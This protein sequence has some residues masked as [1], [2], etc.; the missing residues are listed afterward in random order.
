MLT[1]HRASF[2]A[3]GSMTGLRAIAAISN[4]NIT[5]DGRRSIRSGD[6][7]GGKTKS[8]PHPLP[9]GC[10]RIAAFRAPLA[11]LAFLPITAP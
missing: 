4:R 2:R 3:N 9:A 1:H 10:D 8:S 11:I 5:P 6:G 7:T